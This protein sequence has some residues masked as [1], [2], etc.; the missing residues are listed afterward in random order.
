LSQQNQH[1]LFFVGTRGGG[2]FE[3]RLV[4]EANIPFAAVDEVFAG[5][6]VG[7]NPLR[8]MTSLVLMSMGIVQSLILLL[9]HQPAAIL[10]TGGWAN[11]PLA[12]AA[13]LRRV[14]MLVY[15]PDIEPGSTIK[16]LAR[17]AQ[18]VAITVP[19]SA[20]Y[21]RTGQTVVTGYPLRQAV[22]HATRDAALQ[23]FKL[24]SSRRT[25][26]VFGGSRGARSINIALTSILPDLL[27][28]P[29][30]ILHVTGTLDYE[31][32][33]TEVAA[34]PD[35]MHYHS[36]AYLDDTMGMALAAA[37]M[38]LSRAG[39]SVLGEFPF[40]GLPA[41]LVPY[42]YAWRYQK[43]NADYL[44]ARGAAVRLD[45]DKMT[46]ELLPLLRDWLHHP[47]KL[48]DMRAAAKALAQPHGAEHL[49]QVLVELAYD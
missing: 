17:F 43:T 45:D 15:L 47:T 37:D 20:Q 4:E 1:T 25:L 29:I 5:P 40:F 38:V 41:I 3:R 2:G 24:D 8:A 10:L 12:L 46:T 44:A 22:Y 16:L 21:F 39:A 42:P 9:R 34:I 26:L 48:K 32:V 28:E 7:V 13:W 27:Q 14:P 11:V 36:D 31:R 23:H 49:A 35:K 30:Q 6:I 33:Q 18:K 19:D